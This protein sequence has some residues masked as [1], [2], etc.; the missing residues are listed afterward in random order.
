VWD[1]I[2]EADLNIPQSRAPTVF[3]NMNPKP[4]LINRNQHR[5]SVPQHSH[6]VS[7]VQSDYSDMIDVTYLIHHGLEL[8]TQPGIAPR[9]TLTQ[10]HNALQSV[11]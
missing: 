7:S 9:P 2:L 11:F 5:E 6:S 3:G 1:L 4:V 10:R 8:P